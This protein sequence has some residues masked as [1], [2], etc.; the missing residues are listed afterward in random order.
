M[1]DTTIIQIDDIKE[2]TSISDNVDIKLLQP[3]LFDSQNIYLQPILGDALLTDIQDNVESG[4]TK[5]DELINDYIIYAL[6]YST[7]FSFLPFNHLKVQRKGLVKQ[8]SDNSVN[9]DMDEFA[10]LSGRVESTQVYYLNRLRDYLDD[11]KELYPLYRSECSI[12]IKN[13]SS[14]IFLGF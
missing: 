2:V 12:G 4:T 7:F 14:G 1:N 5:Y 11:N 8:S 6:S 3:F 10:M 9:I 13:S